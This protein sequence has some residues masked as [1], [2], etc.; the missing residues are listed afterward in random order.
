MQQPAS[1]PAALRET[2]RQTQAA[3]TATKPAQRER[4]YMGAASAQAGAIERMAFGNSNKI[5]RG[6][7]V[8]AAGTRARHPCHRFGWSSLFS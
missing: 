4:D 7:A 1:P 3:T 8:A 5:D 6:T 2:A